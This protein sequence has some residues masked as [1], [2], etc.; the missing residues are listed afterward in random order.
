[1]KDNKLNI[2]AYESVKVVFNKCK[3]IDRQ[4]VVSRI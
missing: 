4:D 1:M 2:P 3:K